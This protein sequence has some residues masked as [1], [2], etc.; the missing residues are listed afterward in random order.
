MLKKI[1][2]AIC[3]L[4]AVIMARPVYGQSTMPVPNGG[5]ENWDQHS[6][7]G[8]TVLFFQ[9]PVYSNFSTPTDWNYM[10]YPVNETLSYSGMSLNVNTDIPL[11]LASQETS[12]VAEG[13]SALKLQTFMLSDIISSTVYSLAQSSIDTSLTNM[14]VPS[15]LSTGAINLDNFMPIMDDIVAN[16]SSL[17]QL[18]AVF[19]GEDINNYVDGGVALNGFAPERLQGY[20]KYTSASAGDNGGVVM[21]GTKYNTATHRREAVGGG[22]NVD[23]IDNGS[24]TPFEVAYQSLHEIDPSY[25]E[26]EPDSLI[27][28]LISSANNNRQQGSVLY[29]DGLQLAQGTVVVEDTC[30][31]PY[32]LSVLAK[33]TTRAVIAWLPIESESSWEIEYGVHGYTLG[34][35]TMVASSINGYTFEGLQPGTSYDCYVRQLCNNDLYSDWAMMT[36]ETDTLPVV[37][38]DSTGIYDFSMMGA[39]VYPNPAQGSFQVSFTEEIPS[40]V[41]LYSVEGKMV[42]SIRPTQSELWVE[43]PCPGMYILKCETSKGTFVQKVIGQ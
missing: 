20:Y 12:S 16:M 14:V 2:I 26:I 35:G 4:C 37:I 23:L 39:K 40:A 42:K 13:S 33:D 19:G 6:G 8:V 7:Y 17:S 34:T 31:T 3:L 38:I 32:Q 28:L 5:F 25:A 36:F 24:Y 9:L 21:I 15:V 1:T 11:I 43:L 27:I 41:M 30:Q 22:Y 18:L 10:S 29:V